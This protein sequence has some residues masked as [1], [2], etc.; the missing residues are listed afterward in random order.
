MERKSTTAWN[1]AHL[2]SWSRSSSFGTQPVGYFVGREFGGVHELV[3]PLLDENQTRSR[4]LQRFACSASGAANSLV[5]AR[6]GATPPTGNSS[7]LA[8][9]TIAIART[10]HRGYQQCCVS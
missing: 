3:R 1:P 5:A 4:L 7:M 2:G 10:R 9:A 6:G 8:A